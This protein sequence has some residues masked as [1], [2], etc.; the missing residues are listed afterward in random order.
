MQQKMMI[1]LSFVGISFLIFFVIVFIPGGLFFSLIKLLLLAVALVLDVIA[2]SSRYYTYILMPFFKQRTKDI[3]ISNES[4]YILSPNS[5]AILRRQGDDMV[6]TVYISVPLY[7][8][9]TE[10]TDEEKVN[11]AT[12]VSRL[13][14][15]NKYPV[16]FTSQLYVMNKDAYIATLQDVIT[17]TETE[18]QKITQ[19]GSDPKKLERVKGQL[20]MWRNMLDSVG[21][22]PSYE[23][24]SYVCVSGIGSKEYEALSI[25]QQRAT[26]VIA[27]IGATFGVQPAIVTG[28]QLLKFVEPEYLIPFSTITEQI[29]KNM[30]KQGAA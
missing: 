10:M 1:M 17:K 30:T 4:A 27:G 7:K 2:I 18:E 16:R 12:S 15:L 22:A 23:L 9:S 21:A 19:D 8:S 11:F 25:A 5:D 24:E 26:E 3:V 13:V 6:A 29:N 28:D 14:G 20:S